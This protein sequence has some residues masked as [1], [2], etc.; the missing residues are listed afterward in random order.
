MFKR[1]VAS[2]MVSCLV[3]SMSMTVFATEVTTDEAA[4]VVEVTT[5]EATDEVEDGI[6]IDEK[7][8][9]DAAL[10]EAV[11]ESEEEYYQWYASDGKADGI[12]NESELA[13]IDFLFITGASDLTG[14]ELLTSLTEIYLEDVDCV[15]FELASDTLTA[16]NIDGTDDLEKIVLS[17]CTALTNVYVSGEGLTSIDLGDDNI[18]ECFMMSNS[19]VTS[20]DFS[21]NTNL[22]VVS[23]NDSESLETLNLSG[24]TELTYVSMTGTKVATVDL[25]DAT[26][27][28]CFVANDSK[29]SKIDVS[30]CP[31]LIELSVTNTNVTSIDVTKNTELWSLDCSNTKVSSL[32]LSNNTELYRLFAL[33][34]NITSLDLSNVT[35]LSGIQVAGTYLE[36]V[37]LNPDSTGT[38]S[39]IDAGLVSYDKVTDEYTLVT[40]LLQADDELVLPDNVTSIAYNAFAGANTPSLI[41]VPT[42]VTSMAIS[43]WG[44][45][46]V[47]CSNLITV[48]FGEDTVVYGDIFDNCK[49]LAEIYFRGVAPMWFQASDIENYEYAGDLADMTLTVY[50]PEG[51]DE[52]ADYPDSD[53]GGTITW[54]EWDPTSEVSLPETETD[55]DTTSS[56][57]T[58][59]GVVTT[60]TVEDGVASATVSNEIITEMIANAILSGAEDDGIVVNVAVETD[61]VVT[62]IALT[63]PMASIGELAGN[64]V[65]SLGV[66]SELVGMSFD[67]AAILAIKEQTG[68]DVTFSMTV[69]EPSGLSD[70]AQ[71]LVGDRPVFSFSVTDADGVKVTDFDG[72]V[73]TISIPYELQDD[74]EAEGIIVYYIDEDGELEA[75]EVVEYDGENGCVVFETTH[76]STYAIAYEAVADDDAT[77]DVDDTTTDEDVTTEEDA[78]SP[79]TGDSANV[80]LFLV[81]F[82]VAAMGMGIAVFQRKRVK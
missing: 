65:V 34:T 54:V 20:M 36:D 60:A 81:I 19:A 59:M 75:M 10:R 28:Q 25:S 37:T 26:K 32:D 52:W 72:G 64:N 8:F 7:N 1:L 30:N 2:V 77:T 22:R 56:T 12:L 66:V 82:A 6:E 63:V 39:K 62:T 48:V 45:V 18:V 58:V 67:E 43:G 78:T 57:P 24:C 17:D 70:E 15:G 3:L 47:N 55:S 27:L 49:N 68:S 50:Y 76:F 73:V 31:E 11:L 38:I 44:G 79:E 16:I 14:I 5:D 23:C 71:A 42:T 13:T 46:F 4:D 51:A 21:G 9:P 61:G 33:N 53:F 69:V 40:S 35:D 41:E 74:E 80:A 29:L